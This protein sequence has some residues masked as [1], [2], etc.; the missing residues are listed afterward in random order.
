[1]TFFYIYSVLDIIDRGKAFM[2][3]LRISNNQDFMIQC[4]E[5]AEKCQDMAKIL[6][7]SKKRIS[8]PLASLVSSLI[9]ECAITL[10]DT[11][12]MEDDGPIIQ[13]LFEN[14]FILHKR[15]RL[16]PI[17][18]GV[19]I[20]TH[21]Y[22]LMEIKQYEKVV[23][24]LPGLMKEQLPL[25]FHLD[26]I[27]ILC[28][29]FAKL[30]RM[31]EAYIP[32]NSA[33]QNTSEFKNNKGAAIWIADGFFETGH[34]KEAF[35][36]LPKS[37]QVDTSCFQDSMSITLISR[38]YRILGVQYEERGEWTEALMSFKT[39]LDYLTI[40]ET[41]YLPRG[42]ESFNRLKLFLYR[43]ISRIKLKIEDMP[44]NF[45]PCIPDYVF[46]EIIPMIP[47]S[48]FKVNIKKELELLESKL[49]VVK[50]KKK[51]KRKK[52]VVVVVEEECSVCFFDLVDGGQEKIITTI[53]NHKFHH[54][55]LKEW[56]D[57]CI[58]HS[59]DITCPYCRKTI[60]V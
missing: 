10:W 31:S 6:S 27:A 5:F 19:L 2:Q 32:W 29:C 23:N 56:R 20:K 50:M 7:V 3:I 35:Q 15:F 54:V 21:M 39:G 60:S 17:T 36:A 4:R 53:C 40:S 46:T 49:H 37:L 42:R 43:A 33:R 55:C 41:L 59:R 22:Y 44:I 58:K 51:K 24:W 9:L 57:E 11:G 28:R 16:E 45:P 1:M 52:K 26:F 18:C 38:F 25:S 8:T 13:D 12:N 47:K 34:V 48:V 30:N 14:A